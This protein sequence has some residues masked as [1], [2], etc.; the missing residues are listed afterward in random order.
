[1]I[2]DLKLFKKK[3]NDPCLKFYDSL[4]PEIRDFLKQSLPLLRESITDKKEWK[5]IRKAL[6][7][8]GKEFCIVGLYKIKKK[9]SLLEY[10]RIYS[11][12]ESF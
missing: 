9:P 1:M 2:I 5:K 12:F 10:E 11:I 7:M 6:Q 8:V 4:F 3:Y